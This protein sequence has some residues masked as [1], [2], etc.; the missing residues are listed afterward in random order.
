MDRPERLELLIEDATMD[1]YNLDEAVYGFLAVLED[2]L[3]F[4]FAAKVVGEEVE[5]T[6]LDVEGGVIVAECRRKGIKY[7]VSLLSLEFNPER[8]DGSEWLEAYMRWVK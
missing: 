7:R 5:V 8:V 6:G 4:P 3:H 1:C 2:N